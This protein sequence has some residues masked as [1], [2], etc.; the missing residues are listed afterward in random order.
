MTPLLAGQSMILLIGV[1]WLYHTRHRV[2]RY[3]LL[4]LAALVLLALGAG[5]F[6]GS[7]VRK[8]DAS[9]GIELH[10]V[11]WRDY[12][13]LGSRLFPWAA[14]GNFECY[15]DTDGTPNLRIQVRQSEHGIRVI[16]PEDPAVTVGAEDGLSK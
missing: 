4:P 5:A 8:T 6:A 3:G 7:L 12:L 1:S 11:L 2:T 9:T 14:L 16:G 13:R 10:D 15:T